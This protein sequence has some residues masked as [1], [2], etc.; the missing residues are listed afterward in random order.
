MVR[1]Y[2]SADVVSSAVV[3]RV[4]VKWGVVLQLHDLRDID[5]VLLG[6]E[7]ALARAYHPLLGCGCGWGS[8]WPHN[9]VS[10]ELRQ[11]ERSSLHRPS[12]FAIAALSSFQS[13]SQ[14]FSNAFRASLQAA[15][16]SGAACMRTAL[17]RHS[18]NGREV[19]WRQ[20]AI[21]LPNVSSW[22]MYVPSKSQGSGVYLVM[23]SPRVGLWHGRWVMSR[24]N[25]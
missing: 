21:V 4:T 5:G 12:A 2:Y 11:R 25:L 23:V 22:Y 6:E 3:A 18:S 14:A 1:S 20:S 13:I 10:F 17:A 9:K 8:G 24:D 7:Q 19:L 15:R 16:R